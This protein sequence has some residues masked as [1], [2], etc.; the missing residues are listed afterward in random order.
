MIIS[1]TAYEKDQLI[2]SIF[3]TQKEIA[4]LLLDHPNQ[5][6]ISHLIYEWHSHRNFFINNAAITNFS[7]NDLKGRY[8]QI[9]NLLE[10]AKNA[11]SI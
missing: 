10:K 6:K 4:S 3:K 11:D 2:R 5:R 7:L 8:N 9:I 1:Q